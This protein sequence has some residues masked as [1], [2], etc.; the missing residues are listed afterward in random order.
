MYMHG[1]STVS[2]LS[3]NILTSNERH[4]IPLLVLDTPHYTAVVCGQGALSSIHAVQHMKA[5]PNG[6]YRA[7]AIS[8]HI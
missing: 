7:I 8:G 3:R 6:S 5:C 4:D 2:I 1:M